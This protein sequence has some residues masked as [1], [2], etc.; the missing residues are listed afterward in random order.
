MD[1]VTRHWSAASGIC[2]IPARRRRNPGNCSIAVVNADT[3]AT[4]AR[5][6]FVVRL[7]AFSLLITAILFVDLNSVWAGGR[8]GGGG[9]VSVRGYTRQDG[10]YVAPHYRS[11][12]DGD[13]SNNWSTKGNINPYTG[14]EGTRVTPPS[15]TPSTSQYSVAGMAPPPTTPAAQIGTHRTNSP[16]GSL[17]TGELASLSHVCSDLAD[18]C[19]RQHLSKLL[20]LPFRPDMSPFSEETRKTVERACVGAWSN[21]PAE[22]ASCRG[23]VLKILLLKQ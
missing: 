1:L 23:N 7:I 15:R 6:S 11:A 20:N 2:G 10:T 5:H 8:G 17:D 4:T 9:A 21:G 18:P 16:P 12:P 22:Y 13:F 14:E 19:V 3:G